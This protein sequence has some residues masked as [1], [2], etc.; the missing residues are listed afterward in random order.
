[1]L[2][3]PMLNYHI[4][5]DQEGRRIVCRGDMSSQ[6]EVVGYLTENSVIVGADGN[7]VSVSDDGALNCRWV[8]GHKPVY[9]IDA[10]GEDTYLDMITAPFDFSYIGMSVETK[11][12]LVSLDGGSTD[13]ILVMA[14]AEFMVLPGI[15]GKAGDIVSA[16]NL[17]AGQNYTAMRI[18]IW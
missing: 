13:N 4:R 2:S 1:M 11:A 16:K 12:A 3:K 9:T 5:L 10:I 17:T 15:P 18:M 8:A 7:E 14:D 6:Y